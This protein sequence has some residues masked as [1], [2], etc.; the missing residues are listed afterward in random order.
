MRCWSVCL[1]G[2]DIAVR[3][4]AVGMKATIE[5]C[6]GRLTSCKPG[7][8]HILL[9]RG[10]RSTDFAAGDNDVSTQLWWQAS[11]KAWE[12]ELLFEVPRA[13]P[14]MQRLEGRYKR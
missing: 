14:E 11:G 4:L 5:V 6:S 9:R 3:G 10:H 12:K 2:F 13:H 1:Q 8:L 7:P